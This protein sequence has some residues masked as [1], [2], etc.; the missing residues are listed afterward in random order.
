MSKHQSLVRHLLSRYNFRLSM[1]VSVV[2]SQI[3]SSQDGRVSCWP[4]DQMAFA[5]DESSQIEEG[6]SAVV[7]QF[8]FEM[9]G[10]S[11]FSLCL[12]SIGLT[13]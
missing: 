8:I 4:R 6:R 3:F 11:I 2:N 1:S 9:M 7:I 10:I 5:P 12:L 13:M